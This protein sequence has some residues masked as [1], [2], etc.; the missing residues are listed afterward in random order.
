MIVNKVHYLAEAGEEGD[1]LQGE[2]AAALG[3]ADLAERV[4]AN[5]ADNQALAA[6]DAR[7]IARLTREMKARRVIR[8]PYLD[9]DVHD[10]GGLAEINRYLFASERERVALAA[11]AE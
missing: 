2:L 1:G 7:N 5:F 8:V 6:R 3:D 10:L 4:R 9:E 11:G